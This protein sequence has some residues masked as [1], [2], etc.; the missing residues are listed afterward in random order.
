MV[1]N[2]EISKMLRFRKQCQKLVKMLEDREFPGIPVGKANLININ[3]IW[4]YIHH[5]AI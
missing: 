1:T 2:V 4:L 5:F 3:I